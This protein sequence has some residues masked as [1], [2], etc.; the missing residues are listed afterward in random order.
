MEDLFI[1]CCL[2]AILL[3]QFLHILFT[4]VYPSESMKN[5][6]DIRNLVDSL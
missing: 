6:E 3:I 1:G 4:P 2:I 5:R